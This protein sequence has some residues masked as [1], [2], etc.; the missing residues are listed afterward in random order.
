[1]D[2]PLS[3]GIKVF[4]C[5]RLKVGIL[6]RCGR[7]AAPTGVLSDTHGACHYKT[8]LPKGEFAG[9]TLISWYHKRF[10]NVKMS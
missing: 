9:K 3:L 2:K 8:H 10:F 7:P 5:L 4:T 6:P 1:M